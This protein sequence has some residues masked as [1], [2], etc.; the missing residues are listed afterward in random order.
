MPNLKSWS[1]LA[2][3]VALCLPMTAVASA[4][5]DPAEEPTPA[6]ITLPELD[7]LAWYRS[8]DLSG[9]Q[10]AS[11]A[12]EVEVGQWTA[13]VEGAGASLAELEYAYQAAFDPSLLP[14]LGGI[15]TVRVAGADTDG[16]RAA[17]VDDIVNQVVSL[18]DEP[19]EPQ[20]ATIGGKDVIVVELPDAAGFADAI[21][22]AS[23]DVAYVVLLAEDLAEQALQQLP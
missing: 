9:P 7:S 19:P 4:Q 16:L 8:I 18:G 5:S 15:A 11:E 12:D 3:A 22:Y 2:L 6:P 1:S 13:L 20:A 14:D 21:V 17:V 10:I 23:G